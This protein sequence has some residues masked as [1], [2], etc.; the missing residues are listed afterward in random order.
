MS[1][2]YTLVQRRVEPEALAAYLN[3]LAGVSRGLSL[4]YPGHEVS[5]ALNGGDPTDLVLLIRRGN[6][7]AFPVTPMD[8]PVGEP[9]MMA[10]VGRANPA[11]TGDYESL[12]AFERGVQSSDLLN[13]WAFR[14]AGPAELLAWT[15]SLTR[16]R[17]G[18]P[19]LHLSAFL[20]DRQDPQRFLGVALFKDEASRDGAVA[21][22]REL[23][24]PVGYEPLGAWQGLL[25][26]SSDRPDS[27]GPYLLI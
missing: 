20:Q 16:L 19:G 23:G 22:L 13:I 5:I 21:E 24:L 14:A 8:P 2:R 18:A 26:L 4:V 1:Q 27:D 12:D 6:G 25:A 17:E 7:E 3:R 11:A 9:P 10:G 15:R